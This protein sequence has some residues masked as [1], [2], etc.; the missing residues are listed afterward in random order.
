MARVQVA[1]DFIGRE[2]VSVLRT[3]DQAERRDVLK[4]IQSRRGSNK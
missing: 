3:E 4:E 1:V 2:T